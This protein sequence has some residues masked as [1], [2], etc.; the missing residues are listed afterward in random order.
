MPISY[1]VSVK[2]QVT[3]ATLPDPRLRKVKY[4]LINFIIIAICA[5]ICVADDFVAISN[6]GRKKRRWFR[7]ILD[8]RAGIPSHDRFNA[9]FSMLS[10]AEFDTLPAELDTG[11]PQG[12]RRA[13]DR[14]RR[15]DT[16]RQLRQGKQQIGDPHDHCLG[17]G[18]LDQPRAVGGRCEEQRDHRD[19][20]IAGYV[21]A[22][23][24]DGDD[25][26]RGLPDGYRPSHPRRRRSLRPQRQGESEYAERWDR[27]VVRR[28]FGWQDAD[29]DCALQA[30]YEQGPWPEGIAMTLRLQRTAR[31]ARQRPLAWAQGDRHGY[32]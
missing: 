7:K 21:A 5:V 1:S 4:P 24:G 29:G 15:Q 16:P 26:C 14:D 31:A 10:P 6:F 18:S 11:A 28:V 32:Q 20:K 2:S 17:L 3:F 12:H 25:R 9:I 19:P 30:Q 27:E 13:G 22:Q 23:G 8:L